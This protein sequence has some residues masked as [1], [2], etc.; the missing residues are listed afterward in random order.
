MKSL[1]LQLSPRIQANRLN[2]ICCGFLLKQHGY[3]SVAVD[4][5]SYNLH[6][7]ALDHAHLLLLTRV[8]LSRCWQLDL[9]YFFES[10]LLG[11][12]FLGVSRE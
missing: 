12:I 4:G 3:F 9:P 11:Y 8:R 1:L 2:L 6:S 10:L 5:G 7:V